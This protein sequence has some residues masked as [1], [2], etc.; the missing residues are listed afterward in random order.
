[1]TVPFEHLGILSRT[2]AE[3]AEIGARPER[4]IG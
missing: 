1:M 4:R 3:N 2:N